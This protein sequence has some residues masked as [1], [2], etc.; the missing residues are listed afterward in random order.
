V[1]TFKFDGTISTFDE[2][3][4]IIMG[5]PESGKATYE[6]VLSCVDQKDQTRF[7]ETTLG[8]KTKAP[9]IKFAPILLANG[10]IV[11]DTHYRE[12]AKDGKL[13]RLEGFT[14]L[15]KVA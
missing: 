6:D 8:I 5:L 4:R 13:L 10:N 7:E 9:I 14:K 15:I 1:G 3:D 12:F 2:T 11:E